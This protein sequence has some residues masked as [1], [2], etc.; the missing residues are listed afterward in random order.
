MHGK[1]SEMQHDEKTIFRTLA[2]PF[3]ATRYHSLIVKKETLPDCF[4]ITAWTDQDEI[5]A[6]RHKELPIEGVQFHPESIMTSVGKELLR[7]FIDTY[8]AKKV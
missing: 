5:M 7:N 6:I 4:E 3:T 1:T 2:N 8:S